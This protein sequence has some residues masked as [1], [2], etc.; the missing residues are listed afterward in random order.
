MNFMWCWIAGMLAS[1]IVVTAIVL[2]TLFK[3]RSDFQQTDNLVLRLIRISCESQL[4]PTLLSLAF[5]I[6]YAAIGVNF[7]LIFFG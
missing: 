1:D 7:F 5:L 4:P 3:N 2:W 6:T